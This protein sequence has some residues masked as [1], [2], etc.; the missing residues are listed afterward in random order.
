[1]KIA[2]VVKEFTATNLRL[3]KQI[4]V[5]DFVYLNM[6]QMPVELDELGAVK[7][8]VEREGLRL[9]VVEG[10]PPID[11]IVFGKEGRD[12]QI[13]QYKKM[14]VN[15]G[16]LGV[17]V[18]CYNFMPQAGA[19]EMVVRTSFRFPE[20]GSA[21]TSQFR[22]ADVTSATFPHDER[23]ITDE[24]MW[25]NL[26]FFLKRIVPVAEGAEV[27]LAMHPDDPPLSPL[28]GLAR[29]MRSIE[30][31]ERLLQIARSPVNGITLCQGCFAEMGAPIPEVIRR[32]AGSIH[33]AHFRDVRGTPHDFH[34]TFPDNGPTDMIAAL[35]AYKES[36][37][38][39]FIRI[40]HVPLLADEEGEYDG[41][42]LH[43]HL[44]A[45]GYLKGLMEPI[46]G[47]P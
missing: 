2:G 14:L 5:D 31:F 34:E 27:K 13:E 20:R 22:S 35:R 38:D 42:G 1:M 3:L 4:G 8:L 15:L 41:Y 37:Y 17:G 6:D 36:G 21:L 46:F 16:K 26:E 25:D 33:F 23:P 11:R 32:F 44:F 47:K 45:I 43:G 19:G 30:N 28:C 40:D 18:L 12:Q 10:G 29:I 9:S 24:Q 7:K 39:S